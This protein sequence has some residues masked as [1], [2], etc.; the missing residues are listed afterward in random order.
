[1][2]LPFCIEINRKLQIHILIG[3]EKGITGKNIN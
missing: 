1:M 2:I 3:L